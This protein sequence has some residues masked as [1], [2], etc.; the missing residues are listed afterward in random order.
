MAIPGAVYGVLMYGGG[1]LFAL[2]MRCFARDPAM[3]AAHAA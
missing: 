1:L 3:Q 2:T